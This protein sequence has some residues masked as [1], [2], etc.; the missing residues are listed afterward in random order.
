[1][2]V[3]TASSTDMHW[4][5]KKI[6]LNLQNVLSEVVKIVNFIKSRPMNSQIFAAVC[7]EILYTFPISPEYSA[8]YY[9]WEA[10]SE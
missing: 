3:A 10:R 2:E 1:L 4:Q 7:E 9:K 5:W 8:V 6:P